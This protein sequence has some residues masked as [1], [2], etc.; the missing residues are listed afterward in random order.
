M[1]DAGERIPCIG[2][3]L[4][5][6]RGLSSHAATEGM[7]RALRHKERFYWLE[8]P[9]SLG[10][11]TVVDVLQA[12]DWTEHQP[13]VRRWARS[14]WEAWTPHHETVRCWAEGGR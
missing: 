8:P 5:L 11:V 6:E 7:R 4:L 9:V 2:F 1:T 12:K 14:A 3:Y 13:W 10:E